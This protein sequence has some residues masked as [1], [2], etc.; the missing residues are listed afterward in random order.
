MGVLE[1]RLLTWSPQTSRLKEKKE[2]S[3]GAQEFKGKERR[4]TGDERIIRKG[5]DS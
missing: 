2:K 1:K 4:D 5:R 3:G